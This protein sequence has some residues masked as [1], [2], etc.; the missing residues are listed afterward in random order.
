VTFQRGWKPNDIV[1]L[2]KGLS[3]R[4]APSLVTLPTER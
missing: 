4:P 3:L 2:K 1:H